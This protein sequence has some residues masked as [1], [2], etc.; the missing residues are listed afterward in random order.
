MVDQ[1]ESLRRLLSRQTR[2]LAVASGKGGVGKTSIAVNLAIQLASE[3]NSVIMLDA[4][5]GMANIEIMFGVRPKHALSEVI[6]GAMQMSEV[7]TPTPY[8][9]QIIAGVS[10]MASAADMGQPQ[11][12]RLIEGFKR[13]ASV[14][15]LIIDTGA[16][17]SRNVIDFV[18]AA[19]D[20]YVVVTP[21][22]TSVQ[23]AYGLIKVL[24]GHPRS[25]I[26]EIHILV[27]RISSA[28]LGETLAAKLQQA[29]RQFLS[30]HVT[31]A[32]TIVEDDH[33]KKGILERIPF[34]V[35][36]PHCDASLEIRHMAHE[37]TS[38]MVIS[39]GGSGIQG[40]IGRLF[41]K[42]EAISRG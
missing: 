34:S 20:V 15:Y 11:R 3:G 28:S 35:R 18:L 5:L 32:G 42:K 27:N 36:Y 23:D 13:L 21:E 1:A 38:E 29:A 39:S 30:L 4:D 31:Y 19:E 22:P 40:M 24:S 25:I 33:V 6:S 8:G 17:I 16:G 9:V 37:L 2:I 41:R 10:G 7:L 26:P 14:D 12:L